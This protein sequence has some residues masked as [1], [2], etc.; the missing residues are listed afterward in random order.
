MD[1]LFL[2]G[3]FT[4]I[5]RYAAWPSNLCDVFAG[6]YDSNFLFFFI[7]SPNSLA[8]LTIYKVFFIYSQSPWDSSFY[9]LSFKPIVWWFECRLGI[10]AFCC[11]LFTLTNPL[12]QS[13]IVRACVHL[14]NYISGTNLYPEVTKTS[15]IFFYCQNAYSFSFLMV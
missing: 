4:D 9:Q 12:K 14:L 6:S 3:R 13:E 1:T 8:I 15:L 5:A 7:P 10:S 11:H 2:P